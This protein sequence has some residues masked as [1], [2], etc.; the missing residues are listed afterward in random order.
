M[1]TIV[2]LTISQVFSFFVALTATLGF[3]DR[4]SNDGGAVFNNGLS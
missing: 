2:T 1:A 4:H 3:V